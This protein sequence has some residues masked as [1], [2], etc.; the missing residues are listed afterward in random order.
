MAVENAAAQRGLTNASSQSTP[1]TIYD[2]AQP[3]AQPFPIVTAPFFGKTFPTTDRTGASSRTNRN[4]ADP[5]ATT[6]RSRNHVSRSFPTGRERVSSSRPV[7]NSRRSRSLPTAPEAGQPDIV[8]IRDFMNYL[9]EPKVM[10]DWDFGCMMY[11]LRDWKEKNKA[12]ELVE[13]NLRK[14]YRRQALKDKRIRRV[15]DNG[16]PYSNLLWYL[17]QRGNSVAYAERH[18]EYDPPIASVIEDYHS[19]GVGVKINDDL[20]VCTFPYLLC[21]TFNYPM[22]LLA[23]YSG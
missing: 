18:E 20:E 23:Y 3:P 17:G 1:F 15:K 19:G 14:L 13:K 7:S 4:V 10:N 21:F 11:N 8:K 16:G 5:V 6:R 22:Y 2:T 12:L 9:I